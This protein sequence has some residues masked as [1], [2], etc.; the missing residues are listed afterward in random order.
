[1]RKH[2]FIFLLI[3]VVWKVAA[4][5]DPQ[6][7]LYQFNP[8]IINPAYAGARDGLSVVANVRNQWV[9]FDGAPKTSVL[10]CH[11][12][13]LNK[14][15]GIG[16][17]IIGDRMGPRKMFGFSGNFAYILKLNNKLKLSFGLNAGYNRYQFNYN[18]I[19]FKTIDNTTKNLGDFNTG[20]VDFNSGFYL[21]SKSFFLGLSFTHIGAKSLYEINM[22]D[23]SFKGFLT[24]RLRTHQFLTIGKSWL[25]NENVVFAPTLAFR[26]V[27]HGQGNIDINFNFFLYKKLWLGLFFRTPYGPGFLLNY[28][29]TP[30]CKVGYS[31]DTGLGNNRRLGAS[32][33]V[34][35]GFDF[36]GQKSKIISPR[37][38]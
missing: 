21:K 33:E 15:V 6:Y 14:N 10:S 27:N 23:T 22:K 37:F 31:Y 3:S 32:H 19:T 20:A 12:P 35:I 1:M 11:A 2:I 8:L 36:L 38:L 17:T 18:E 7:N 25:L 9:G 30:K 26:G 16:F 28:Y 4:Q 29:V 5:Q 34:S 24:Y 13:V